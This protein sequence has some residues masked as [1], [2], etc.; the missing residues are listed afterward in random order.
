M[1]FRPFLVGI[2][3]GIC[4]SSIVGLILTWDTQWQGL[5]IVIP[6]NA[7]KDQAP[8]S[9]DLGTFRTKSGLFLK[10]LQKMKYNNPN[11]SVELDAEIANV[12][13][14]FYSVNKSVQLFNLLDFNN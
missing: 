8:K 13:L 9:V 5:P 12:N 10:A 14:F 4:F 1:N 6:Q 11:K 2:I 7:P 3:T